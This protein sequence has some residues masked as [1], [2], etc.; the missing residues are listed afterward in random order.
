MNARLAHRLTGWKIDIV[1]DT[2]FA[3][4][5]A[6]AAF[7][8]DERRGGRLL[9]PLRGDPLER[10]ALPERVAPGLEVLRRAGPPGARAAR[11]ATTRRTRSS[12]ESEPELE[13]LADAAEPEAVTEDAAEF[14]EPEP[15]EEFRGRP[16]RRAGR[17]RRRDAR[18]G[19]RRPR[20]RASRTTRDDGDADRARRRRAT[21]EQDR[22]DRRRRLTRS[23]PARA[24]AA[25]RRRRELQRFHARGR[26][27]SRRARAPAAASTRAAGSPASSARRAHRGFQPNAAPDRP[28]RPGLSRGS[29]LDGL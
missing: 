29:T 9:R 22:G 17:R 4:Q 25:R 11:A 26:R 10:Q 13:A 28:R 8:G 7:G 6:E 14:G 18:V 16:G 24:A 20:R 21:A 2:E 1:S 3:Q 5:E 23:G 19:R 15:G 27:C 12:T